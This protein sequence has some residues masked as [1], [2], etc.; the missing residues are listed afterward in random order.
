MFYAS[1]SGKE[2]DQG[3]GG[4][5]RKERF[6]LLTDGFCCENKNASLSLSESV[7]QRLGR[8]HKD[9]D[10]G[11]VLSGVTANVWFFLAKS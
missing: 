3:G 6:W 2:D 8:M 7:A 4:G 10:G 5:W 11:R 9:D 1:A